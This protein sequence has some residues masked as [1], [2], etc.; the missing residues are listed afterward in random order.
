MA[1]LPG[2]VPFELVADGR[3]PANTKRLDGRSCSLLVPGPRRRRPGL[4][5]VSVSS[6]VRNIRRE[7]V[8]EWAGSRGGEDA[9]HG[10]PVDALKRTSLHKSDNTVPVKSKQFGIVSCLD[11]DI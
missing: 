9:Q 11:V 4:G 7:G 1:V 10:L 8:A 6:L 3:S 5:P 2:V